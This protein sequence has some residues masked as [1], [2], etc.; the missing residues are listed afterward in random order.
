MPQ[1]DANSHVAA[2]YARSILDLAN[3][4]QQADAVGQEMR[5]LGQLF[6]QTEGFAELLAN[7]GVAESERRTLLDRAFRGR[8]SPL[9]MNLLGV[10]QDKG[11][12]PMVRHV[13]R[14]YQ[15]LLDAQQGNVE[16]EVTVAQSLSE[17]QQRDLRQRIGET[18]GKNIV[19]HETVDP[20][21]IGGLVLR[22]RD[23]LIDASV[24]TQIDSMREKILAARPR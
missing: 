2:A 19:M 21:I 13:A 8:L 5:D 1:A 6:E 10:M 18:L 7:P 24:R 9:V 11:R 16:V 22:V 4:Q 14:V 3:E 20:Q 23:R 12:L 15:E 17:Q